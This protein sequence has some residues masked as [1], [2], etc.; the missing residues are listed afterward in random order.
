ML[1]HDLIRMLIEQTKVNA[2]RHLLK[3]TFFLGADFSSHTES[4][5]YRRRCFVLACK[6]IEFALYAASD[7]LPELIWPTKFTNLDP[8][9]FSQFQCLLVDEALAFRNFLLGGS[10]SVVSRVRENIVYRQAP[11]TRIGH[12]SCCALC[13][14][15][16]L[17]CNVTCLTKITVN[18]VHRICAHVTRFEYLLVSLFYSIKYTDLLAETPSHFFAGEGHVSGSSRWFGQP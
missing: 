10:E 15:A 7:I 16:E 11:V 9:T 17:L 2:L 8:V 1:G 4:T 5:R 12:L 3:D 6:R 14:Q 13:V 18:I